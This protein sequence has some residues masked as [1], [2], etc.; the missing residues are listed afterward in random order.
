MGISFC[1]EIISEKASALFRGFYNFIK[2][3]V[4]QTLQDDTAQKSKKEKIDK[5]E[6]DHEAQ[7][8]GRK[9]PMM[10]VDIGVSQAEN[11]GFHTAP[12]TCFFT[13]K[14]GG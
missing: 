4:K 6:S 13:R 5:A 1:V 7:N 14:E 11:K 3:A 2:I 12:L 8:K 10:K 9:Q